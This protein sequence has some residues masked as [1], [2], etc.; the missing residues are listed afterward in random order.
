[1]CINKLLLLWSKRFPATQTLCFLLC[2]WSCF[3]GQ[4][5]STLRMWRHFFP[6]C[7]YFVRITQIKLDFTGYFISVYFVHFRIWGWYTSIRVDSQ[8][9]FGVNNAQKLICH[10]KLTVYNTKCN[11]MEPL[12]VLIRTD[13]WIT[14]VET[15]SWPKYQ[16]YTINKYTINHK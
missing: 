13:V 4:A 10:L 6:T 12:T 14:L 15:I 11:L 3:W 1:M 5:L 2:L 16:K 8:R 7:Q 9:F